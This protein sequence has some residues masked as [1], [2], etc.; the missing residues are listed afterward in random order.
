M[1][2]LDRNT[3]TPGA[4]ASFSGN[5]QPE[6]ETLFAGIAAGKTIMEIGTSRDIFQQ[7]ESANCA[8]YLRQGNVK[9]TVTSEEGKEAIFA[10]VDAGE[11]FGEGCLL[12]QTVRSSTASALTDCTLVRL[13]KSVVTSLLHEQRGFSELL[14]ANLLLRNI[15]YEEDL[16]DQLF[17]T[18]EQRLARNLLRLARVNKESG[19]E[20]VLPKMNQETLAQMVGTTR[21]R[22]SHFMT[23]FKQNGLVD[24]NSR[25]DLLVHSK[26]LSVV[27]GCVGFA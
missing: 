10:V 25:G 26:L 4:I 21:S 16:V 13:D 22:V 19:A 8:F 9:L 3:S 23:K 14:V 15:R 11:F 24:Y 20:R 1:K 18:S 17:N 27:N 7:G 2:T 12:G 5:K 6:W